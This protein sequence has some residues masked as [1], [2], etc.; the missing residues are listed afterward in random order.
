MHVIVA[1]K[2]MPFFKIFSKF[3]CA[4]NNKI[5]FKSSTTDLKLAIFIHTKIYIVKTIL[6]SGFHFPSSVV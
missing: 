6:V 5:I 3:L 1:R 4:I 2:R